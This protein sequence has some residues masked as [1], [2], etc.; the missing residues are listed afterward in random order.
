MSIFRGFKDFFACAVGPV[1][2]FV[3]DGC[4]VELL[5]PVVSDFLTL[6]YVFYEL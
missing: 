3:A 5:W 1:L 2:S 6:L 4:G